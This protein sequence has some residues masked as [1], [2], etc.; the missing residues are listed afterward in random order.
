MTQAVSDG[1]MFQ[2]SLVTVR[3]AWE[4]GARAEG[5]GGE[6]NNYLPKEML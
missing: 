2:H 6:L 1:H 3:F 4:C 5:D